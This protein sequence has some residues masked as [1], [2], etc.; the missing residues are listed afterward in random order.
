M[1]DILTMDLSKFGY[2]ELTMAAELLNA[3]AKQE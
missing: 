3:M 1:G 2:R